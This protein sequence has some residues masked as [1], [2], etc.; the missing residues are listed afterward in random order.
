MHY[1]TTWYHLDKND[2]VLS[3][4]KQRACFSSIINSHNFEKECKYLLYDFSNME[5]TQEEARKYFLFLKSIPEFKELMPKSCSQMAKDM[6][7]K[8]DLHKYNGTK[9]FTMLTLI[10]AV[11]EDPEIVREVI[12]FDRKVKYSIS[13]FGILK[14]CGSVHT[15]NTNHWI[16]MCVDKRNLDKMFKT[17]IYWDALE[18]C[19][20][21]GLGRNI[22]NTFVQDNEGYAV[23]QPVGQ[24]DINKVRAE[25]HKP[26]VAVKQQQYETAVLQ[27]GF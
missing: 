19:I 13:N 11:V 2:V 4:Y 27:L 8:V 9:I 24:A 22:Y 1:S 26:K 21:T 6:E 18:P 5:V 20:K 16:T 10:R 23:L 3:A 25:K 14:L 12:S 7:Y 17:Q 15:K